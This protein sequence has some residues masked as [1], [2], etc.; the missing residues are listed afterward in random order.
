MPPPPADEGPLSPPAKVGARDAGESM[1][2]TSPGIPTSAIAALSMLRN[3]RINSGSESGYSRTSSLSSDLDYDEEFANV[4]RRRSSEYHSDASGESAAS[5]A[6]P[7]A[8][9]M[10]PGYALA[11]TGPLQ[12]VPLQQ[13]YVNNGTGWTKME[14]PGT[15]AGQTSLQGGDAYVEGFG[16]AARPVKRSSM[17]TKEQD[18]LLVKAVQ[19][20][21][22][23][24]WKSI[25]ERVGAD[26]SHIQ[27][28]HRWQKVLDPD[29]VKGPW[30]N[31]EDQIIMD[32]VT[33]Y[34]PK[35]WSMIAKQLQGRTGKQCRERWINQLDPN[36]SKEV[37]TF[38]ICRL[39]GGGSFPVL[40]FP[41]STPA[42]YFIP[43]LSLS[44]AV[45]R[46]AH[47][48]SRFP[49]FSF[50]LD[51]IRRGPPT[52]TPYCAGPGRIS[53]TSGPRSPSC[54]QA[55][56]TT[57]SRTAGTARCGASP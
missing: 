22:G 45:C 10:Q 40:W 29:L 31:A 23:K 42:R 34:G 54:Y 8:S 56:A 51:G 7:M 25:S 13:A 53:A 16:D 47:R 46:S 27:C 20:Y 11:G 19:M 50:P 52:R 3:T 26:K 5:G 49:G 55:G 21:K 14:S 39:G 24:S 12:G 33:K 28:L 17:W 48:H 6:V 9:G 38:L 36:I 37:S 1:T 35:R 2:V 18:D 30:T 57:P 41:R 4:K 43:S 15:A 44:L 32:M